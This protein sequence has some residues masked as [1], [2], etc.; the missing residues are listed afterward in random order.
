MAFFATQHLF[1]RAIS[2]AGIIFP[3]SKDDL[4]KQFGDITY[5]E[6]Q[7]VEIP[8]ADTVRELPLDYYHN[9]SEF[10]NAYSAYLAGKSSANG[11]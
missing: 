4:I 11:L 6:E 3:A 10:W 1:V 7:G 8:A 9:G 5:Q 2:E